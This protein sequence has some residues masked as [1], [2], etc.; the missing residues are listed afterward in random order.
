MKPVIEQNLI[1]GLPDEAMVELRR[2]DS[3]A[4]PDAMPTEAQQRREWALTLAFEALSRRAPVVLFIDDLQWT[5]P[6]SL[7]FMRCLMIRKRQMRILFIGTLRTDD[8][9]GRVVWRGLIA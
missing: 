6:T 5:D 3:Q 7:G 8:P 2:L 9:E 4:I 1:P